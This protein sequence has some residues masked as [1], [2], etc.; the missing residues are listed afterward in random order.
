MFSCWEETSSGICDPLNTY[1]FIL[2]RRTTP[3]TAEQRA[4]VDKALEQACVN[5][6][7]LKPAQH[8]GYCMYD[9]DF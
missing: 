4:V 9:E 7:T 3:L 2:Q 5:P 1:A 6:K 8:Y